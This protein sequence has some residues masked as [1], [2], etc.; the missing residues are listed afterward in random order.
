MVQHILL[1]LDETLFD[2]RRSEEEAINSVLIEIGVG[3]NPSLRQL[4]SSISESQWRLLE[5][6][7][8]DLPTL[9]VRR[10]EILLY[11]LMIDRDASEIAQMYEEQLS[12]GIH[13]LG[14]VHETLR[15]LSQH[16]QLY[17]ATNGISTIQRRRIAESGLEPYFTDIFISQELGYTKP[18]VEYYHHIFNVIRPD[19]L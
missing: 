9:R 12:Q 8:L 7:Q 2:F 10:F 3:A 18:H 14:D 6:Q 15:K 16:Y 13:L 11:A 5:T 4:Y 1:D 19:S 17:A